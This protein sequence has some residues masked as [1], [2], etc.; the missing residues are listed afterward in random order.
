MEK[1]SILKTLINHSIIDKLAH[2]EKR[3]ENEVTDLD[4]LLSTVKN[5]ESNTIYK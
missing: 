1:N 5:L 4:H 3:N 2:L